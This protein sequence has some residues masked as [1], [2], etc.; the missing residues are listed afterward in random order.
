VGQGAEIVTAK[1]VRTPYGYGT[2]DGDTLE[3]ADGSGCNTDEVLPF[4][5]A[6]EIVFI[7][8][9]DGRWDE[10]LERLPDRPDWEHSIDRVRAILRK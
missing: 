6:E 7:L 4:D 10:F 8:V 9:H 1:T 2:L 3:F 5:A